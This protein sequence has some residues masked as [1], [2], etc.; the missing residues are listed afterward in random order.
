M[1]PHS[2]NVTE[3]LVSPVPARCFLTGIWE[4]A[5]CWQ[6]DSKFQ[7][8]DDES[9][10]GKQKSSSVIWNHP[11]FCTPQSQAHS[12]SMRRAALPTPQEIPSP[13]LHLCSPNRTESPWDTKKN[14]FHN[15]LM[16][17]ALLRVFTLKTHFW[18]WSC[19]LCCQ[20]SV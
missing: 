17:A 5:G 6:Q 4:Q 14:L 11:S 3:E 19:F 18:N 7:I 10:A 9:K 1:F 12:K 8:T 15:W 2:H 20:S 16:R 13:S